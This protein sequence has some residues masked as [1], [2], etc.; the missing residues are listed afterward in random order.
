MLGIYFA[1]QII[2]FKN[3]F[4]WFIYLIES[5]LE[6][7]ILNNCSWSQLPYKEKTEGPPTPLVENH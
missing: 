3:S 1:V 6:V 4:S 5:G 7:F 2:Q